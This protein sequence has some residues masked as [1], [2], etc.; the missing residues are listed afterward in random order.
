MPRKR[1]LGATLR[2]A[3]TDPRYARYQ[4]RRAARDV[5]LRVRHRGDHVAYYRAVMDD[6]IVHGETTAVGDRSS[7]RWQKGGKP[8]FDYLVARGL[9]PGHRML[10]IGCGNLRAGR[11]FIRH[12]EPGHYYGIDISPEAIRSAQAALAEAGLT[13]KMP[14]LTVV[15]DMTFRFLPDEIFDFVHAHSVFS[16]SPMSVI[17]ECFAHVGRILK[18]HGSFYFTYNR[19][20]G[21]ERTTLREDFY[22]RTETLL[23]AA[24]RHG[25][26]GEFMAD[27]EAQG[28]VQSTICVR[29]PAPSA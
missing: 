26:V 9:Q 23:D 3:V 19:S 20:G 11:R 14:Y 7:Q 15:D 21:R 18:P 27:W 12:L 24:E 2:R 22:Y 6:A 5:R 17:E 25:L 10:D 13:D 16:H 8:Q 28:R 1:R 29:R 4:I